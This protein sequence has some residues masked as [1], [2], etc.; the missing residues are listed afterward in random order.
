MD[1]DMVLNYLKHQKPI[2][3]I[4]KYFIFTKKNIGIVLLYL[5]NKIKIK[6]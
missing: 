1:C 4:V 5:D 3:I 6:M 2:I